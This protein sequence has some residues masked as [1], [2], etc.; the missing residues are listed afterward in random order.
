MEAAG[1]AVAEAVRR[2]WRGG[3]V[4]VLAGPGNN[5]GDGWV[6]ARRLRDT[7]FRVTVALHGDRER[8]TGDA[9]DAARRYAGV[10]VRAT[11]TAFREAGLIVDA[12]YGA[13]ARLPL[14]AVASDLV[15]AAN[16][17]GAVIVAVDLPSGVEGEGGTTAGP[18]IRAG[19]TVT[20]FRLKPGHV[21]LPGRLHCGVLT[22]AQIGIPPTV[23]AEIGPRASLNR[24]ALWLPAWRAPDPA[25]HK[26][27]R[28][29][30]LVLSGPA[31]AAGAA[32]MAAAAALRIGAGLVTVGARRSAMAEIATQTTAV[33]LRPVDGVEGL[34]GVLEDR[35]FNALVLGPGLG[36]GEDTERLAETAIR[37]GRAAVL[38]ADALTS[39]ADEPD[40]LFA[41]IAAGGGQVV[42]TPHDGEFARL[43]PDLGGGSRLERARLGA[44]RSGASVLLKGPDTVVATPDG[45]AT[46]ADNAP[47]DLAT[48]GAGDVLA[49]LVG[50]LLA[51]GMPAFEA[52]A[53][54]VWIHGEAATAFG[55]GLTA[56]DLPGEIAPVLRRLLSPL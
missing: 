46:I 25:G 35:R 43:F 28:G 44:A 37:A 22:L 3:P 12:L 26:Y 41:A 30:V 56:E 23:L 51:R 39:F 7:G 47:P 18:A 49:G 20:F 52:A 16:D 27:D 32:R 55:A 13:G 1:A 45:R 14:S 38:D 19:E 29:H 5:G 48:A 2:R 54:A 15:A 40:R 21:L 11:P 50:G 9:A 42:L 33:M 10:V 53:A 4:V 8:L 6:A 24:P 36:V 17:A 31:G 34:R